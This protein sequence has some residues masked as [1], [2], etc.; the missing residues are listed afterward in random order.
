VDGGASGS[1][2]VTG[3]SDTESSSLITRKS[4]S[5]VGEENIRK[6]Y[7]IVWEKCGST[8]ASNDVY[9]GFRLFS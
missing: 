7:S 8:A 5:E 1:C 4:G 2:P 3:V 9:L 6:S